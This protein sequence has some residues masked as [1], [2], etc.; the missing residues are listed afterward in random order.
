MEKKQYAVSPKR[1]RIRIK[2][3]EDAQHCVARQTV[4]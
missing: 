4:A 2:A 1:G 3:E